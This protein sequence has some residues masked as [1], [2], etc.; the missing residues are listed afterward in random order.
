MNSKGKSDDYRMCGLDIDEK[1]EWEMGLRLGGGKGDKSWKLMVVNR[2]RL[3]M[4]VLRGMTTVLLWTGVIRLMTMGEMW[5][6][7]LLKT[8][9]S[10]CFTTTTTDVNNMSHF[11]PNFSLPPKSEFFFSSLIF[12]F[13]DR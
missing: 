7:R 5:G 3:M 10:S 1:K 6:P 2:G 12:I 13:S 8:W 11:P 4:W 9:P